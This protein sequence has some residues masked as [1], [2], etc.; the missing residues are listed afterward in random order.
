MIFT[1][2]HAKQ[3]FTQC[4]KT[5]NMSLSYQICT[6]LM[7][8]AHS[9]KLRRGENAILPCPPCA[10]DYNKNMSAV[11]RHDQ[12]VRNYAIDRKS[13]RW[14]VRMFVN[15]LSP[16]IVNAYIIYKENFKNMNMPAP[17]KPPKPLEHDKF[18]SGIIHK[19]IGNFSCHRQPGPPAAPHP[20]P[21]H[22]REHDSVNLVELGLLKFGRC[23][24]FCISVKGAKRKETGFGCRT[25]VKRLCHSGCHEQYHRQKNIF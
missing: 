2:W 23:H 14:W 16:I 5:Q 15:F 13:R 7:V 8:I 25:C 9:W 6:P 22:G 12:L 18:M 3:Q 21:F 11:D 4:G 24:H 10:V 1:L 20:T 17:E 19:L